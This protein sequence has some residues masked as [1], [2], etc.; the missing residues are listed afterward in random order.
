MKDKSCPKKLYGSVLIKTLKPLYLQE[1]GG[2][3][4]HKDLAISLLCLGYC[5]AIYIGD[6]N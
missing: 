3:S 4:H 2:I 6:P 1:R 5:E